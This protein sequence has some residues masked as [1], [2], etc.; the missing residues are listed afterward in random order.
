[1]LEIGANC[2][3]ERVADLWLPAPTCKSFKSALPG[4]P[5]IAAGL[6][7]NAARKLLQNAAALIAAKI[8]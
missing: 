8:G 1:V 5:K 4:P 3:P 6:L 2:R 7:H